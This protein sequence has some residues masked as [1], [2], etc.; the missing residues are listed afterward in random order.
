MDVAFE[1]SKFHISQQ[2]PMLL[3]NSLPA[4]SWFCLTQNSI[5]NVTA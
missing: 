3:I 5:S 2:G 1:G 4:R